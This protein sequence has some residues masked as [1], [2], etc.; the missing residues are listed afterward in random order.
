[1]TG[2]WSNSYEAEQHLT[3]NEIS[4]QPVC[5]SLM[6]YASGYATAFFGSPV[7]AIEPVCVGKGD[8]HC[9]WKLQHLS[10]WGEE[11][12]PYMEALRPFWKEE[13]QDG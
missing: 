5:W 10:A 12:K 1:M 4:D 2:I 11:A 6:G 3:F 13:R 8:D 9:E 7:I